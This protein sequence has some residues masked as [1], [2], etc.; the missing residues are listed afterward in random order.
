MEAAGEQSAE[1]WFQLLRLIKAIGGQIIDFLAQIEGFQRMLWEKRKFIT[2][3]N[4]CIA[5]RCI[6]E[7]FHG[8]IS[9]N[10]AQWA[11]WRS[12]SLLND[13]AVSLA[14]PETTV[15]ERIAYL[16][17]RGTFM[18]DTAHFSREFTDRLLASIDDLDAATDGLLVHGDNWQAPRLLQSRYQDTVQCVHIDPP[19]NTATRGSST[20]TAISTQVGWR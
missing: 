14:D 15:E 13:E 6:P 10:E 17:L 7:E 3:T 1:G 12:L 2:E 16:K 19:Y 18:L 20:K 4:Y 9:A 5:V 11:E 8:E